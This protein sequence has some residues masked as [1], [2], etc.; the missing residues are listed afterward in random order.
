MSDSWLEPMR[1]ETERIKG[2]NERLREETQR[3]REENEV[4]SKINVKEQFGH[5][6]DGFLPNENEIDDLRKSK[7]ELSQYGKEKFREL[8]INMKLIDRYNEFYNCTRAGLPHGSPISMEH[9]QA[10]SIKSAIYAFARKYNLK[11]SIPVEEL[12]NL[13]DLIEK[14]GDRTVQE[15]S[16]VHRQAG[17]DTL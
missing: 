3:L 8:N 10:I 15:V 4:L 13:A 17:L 14:Q 5:L 16:E 7:R 9:L 11:E 12:N 2:E 1:K 6:L